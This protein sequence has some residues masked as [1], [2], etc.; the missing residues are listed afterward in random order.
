METSDNFRGEPAKVGEFGPE[1]LTIATKK[2]H[3]LDFEEGFGK[4]KEGLGK[5]YGRLNL[6]EP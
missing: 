4:L 1:M 6:E 3:P 2:G 5:A